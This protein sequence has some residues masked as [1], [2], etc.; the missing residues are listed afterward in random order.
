MLQALAVRPS[1]FRR[2]HEY[3]LYA[4]LLVNPSRRRAHVIYELVS[5]HNY[6]TSRTLFRN[7][8]YWKNKPATL[9]DACEALARVA[10]EA[11]QLTPDDCVLDAG[12]GFADQDM[13]RVEHFAPRRVVGVNVTQTQVEVA[14][15]RIAERGLSDRIAAEA[16]SND[17]N[18]PFVTVRLLNRKF[19]PGV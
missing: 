14:R 5:T 6:L 7:V 9:D 13:Y 11:A 2:L 8:G 4:S 19:A 1:W 15:R 16:T 12:F 3:L 10:G 18:A 17:P